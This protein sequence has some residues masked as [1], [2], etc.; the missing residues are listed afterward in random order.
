MGAVF[1]RQAARDHDRIEK[2]LHGFAD[3][4][5]KGN[6]RDGKLHAGHVHIAGVDHHAHVAADGAA[7]HLELGARR[8]QGNLRLLLKRLSFS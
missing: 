4:G 5:L 3:G 8:L 7:G 2:E 6:R 1:R